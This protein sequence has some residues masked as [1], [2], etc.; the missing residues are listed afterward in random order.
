MGPPKDRTTSFG[1]IPIIFSL[2]F[3]FFEM[4]E[5]R[6]LAINHL[7]ENTSIVLFSIYARY[8]LSRGSQNQG[9]YIICTFLGQNGPHN[10]ACVWQL[11]RFRHHKS[12]VSCVPLPTQ[13]PFIDS[14]WIFQIKKYIVNCHCRE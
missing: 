5:G 12:R 6:G 9:T 1:F 10:H 2:S 7:I 14:C 8:T 4:T 13:I 3:N 11:F